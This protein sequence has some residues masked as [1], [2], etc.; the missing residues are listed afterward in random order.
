[1]PDPGWR[2]GDPPGADRDAVNGA[3]CLHEIHTR[4]DPAISA[5]R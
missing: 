5:G 3:A 1:L 2:F 4:S